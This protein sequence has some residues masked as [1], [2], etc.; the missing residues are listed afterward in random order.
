VFLSKEKERQEKIKELGL[1]I[2]KKPDSVDGKA[3][4]C[5]QQRRR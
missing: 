4:G 1:E 5:K 3:Q 2:N